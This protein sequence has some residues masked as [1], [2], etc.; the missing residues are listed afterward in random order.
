MLSLGGERANPKGFES[1][2]APRSGYA[3]TIM[4]FFAHLLIV[5]YPDHHQS[6]INSLLY[7]LGPLHKI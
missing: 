6:L 3:T 7:Y 4:I 1:L 2:P 5:E